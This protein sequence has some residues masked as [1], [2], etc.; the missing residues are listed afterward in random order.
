MNN[1][2]YKHKGYYVSVAYKSTYHNDVLID[3]TALVF[4]E[5]NRKRYWILKNDVHE[6]YDRLSLKDA[7]KVFAKEF[8]KGNSAF[9]SDAEVSDIKKIT[10]SKLLN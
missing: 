5:K 10:R 2:V 8:I 9:W 1:T 4:K 7:K 3:E 6:I